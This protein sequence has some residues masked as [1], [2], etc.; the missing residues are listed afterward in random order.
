[1]VKRII[2]GI[3]IVLV[4]AVAAV[5]GLAATKPDTFRVARTATIKA[6]PEKVFA[7]VNDFREWGAWS[8]WEKK[9]PAMKRSYSGPQSGKG[10]VY[11]WDGDK[12][13]GQG[14]MEIAD[15]S[16]PSKV[17]LKL[18]F[19]RPFEAHNVAE[20][21]MMPNGDA[22][23]VSWNMQGPVPYFAKIL[24]MFIDVDRMVGADFE[25]GLANLKA[26]AEKQAS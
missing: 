19:V 2:L 1:M 13:V 16:P 5:L 17:T 12:N 8:P 21:T 14:R 23:K 6:P 10:A 11:A 24:H 3:V 20:F 4:V 7:L 25:A 18:D 26:L 22:T 9:D 15:V